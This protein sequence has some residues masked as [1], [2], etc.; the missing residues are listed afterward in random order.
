MVRFTILLMLRN[1]SRNLT[2]SL[3]TISGLVIGLTVAITTFFWV[4]Y[5]F[6]FNTENPDAARVYMV[7]TNENSGDDVVTSDWID[8]PNSQDFPLELLPEIEAATR[9]AETDRKISYGDKWIQKS[10]VFADTGFIQVH[11][12]KIVVGNKAHQL[13]DNHSIMISR[14]LANELF[15]HGDALGKIIQLNPNAEF[16]ITAVYNP[17]S[18]NNELSFVEFILP[19]GSRKSLEND[20]AWGN[21]TGSSKVFLKLYDG[22]SPEVVEQKV[23]EGWIKSLKNE[24]MQTMMLFCM[25]DWHLYRGFENGK[26]SGGRIIYITT[27]CVAALFILIMACVNYVNIATARA[28]QRAKEIGVRKVTGATKVLLFRQFMTES[29]V[30]TFVSIVISLIIVYT[31]LPL[32]NLLL[33]ETSPFSLADPRL[34]F[35]LILVLFFTASLAG[36][37]PALVM[38]SFNPVTVL[39]GSLS[40][41]MRS[42][43]M[44]GTL[45]VFQYT[46]SII[47]IFCALIMWQQTNYLLTKDLGY[48]RNEMIAVWLSG[49]SADYPKDFSYEHLKAEIESHTSIVSSAYCISDPMKI[50]AWTDVNLVSRPFPNPE[51]FAL[52]NVD[53]KYIPTAKMEIVKGRNFSPEIISDSSNFIINEKAVAALDFDNPIGQRITVNG[54]YLK[55]EIIGVV[56]DFNHDDIH[57][58]VNPLVFVFLK[59]SISES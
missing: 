48:D 20:N 59:K 34:M 37:Y 22:S 7:L 27:F 9:L 14:N 18:K 40:S 8:L 43:G 12:P 49:D 36:S 4:R 16:K 47:M 28:T 2:Y 29:L 25:T 19:F 56:K 23:N 44:R 24:G 35:G 17:F 38:S 57:L 42:L 54:G 30:I 3:I 55:G 33:V 6:S 21:E 45:V 51:I 52:A 5:E 1:F 32:V 31:I 53:E 10:G 50:T 13:E 39:K 15:G 41:G 58:P 26:Q 11:Q 46:L